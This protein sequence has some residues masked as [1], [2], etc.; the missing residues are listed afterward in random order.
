MKLAYA[1][2]YITL[3]DYYHH[4]NTWSEGQSGDGFWTDLFSER[5]VL[6]DEFVGSKHQRRQSESNP[7]VSSRAKVLPSYIQYLQDS[8][9]YYTS[10]YT[11]EGHITFRL[12]STI[13]QKSHYNNLQCF[14]KNF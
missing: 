6:G 9:H 12:Y 14:L 1:H 7:L 3:C 4:G 11:Q 10:S 5:V 2:W 13:L 8:I